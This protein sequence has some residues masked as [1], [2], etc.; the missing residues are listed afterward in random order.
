M[1]MGAARS[2]RFIAAHQLRSGRRWLAL[3]LVVLSLSLLDVLVRVIGRVVTGR[4]AK[5]RGGFLFCRRWLCLPRCPFHFFGRILHWVEM[6]GPA[7]PLRRRP[8]RRCRPGLV[9]QR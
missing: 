4:A 9:T 3:P 1:L 2:A 7:A 5:R 6:T 8:F